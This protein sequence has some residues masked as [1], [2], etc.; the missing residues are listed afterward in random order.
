[1]S[2]P[3]VL[4]VV[5]AR[6]EEATVAL[7]VKA[8]LAVPAID[9]VLVVADGST[10]Q[11]PDEALAAGARVLSRPSRV[12]KGRAVEAALAHG[13]PADIYVLVD[14]D[15]GASASEAELLLGEV[16]SGRLDLAIGTLPAQSGG[17]FG[18]VKRIAA[19]WIRVLVGFQADAPLS[20][21]RA[22]RGELLHACRPLAGRF[23]LEAAMT[24]D[25]L[26]LGCRVGEV[27]VRMTHRPTGRG[28]A[29]MLHR[30]GQG[31][32][33][34]SAVLPRALGLR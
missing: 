6:N 27:P 4:A 14:G 17:G 13:E 29:G 3:H 15:V 10:D 34:L 1:M 22:V 12:G 2:S 28:P 23:G 24:I 26:R 18:L 19:W 33:L 25:A 21:Q 7:T 16:L 20:G 32:D 30:A 9:D 31:L 5:P 11:T 8:L